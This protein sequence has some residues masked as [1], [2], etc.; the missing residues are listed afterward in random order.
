MGFYENP[1]ILGTPGSR[2]VFI[3]AEFPD[4]SLSLQPLG[5][6]FPPRESP[7][8]AFLCKNI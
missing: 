7:R 5:A 3:W 6:P 2:G 8:G 4:V 1:R